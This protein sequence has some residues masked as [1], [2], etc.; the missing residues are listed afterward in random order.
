M[1]S[2][3]NSSRYQLLHVY[4][5]RG[6]C[7]EFYAL[8]LILQVALAENFSLLFNSLKIIIL[9]ILNFFI[10]TCTSTLINTTREIYL[11][12]FTRMYIV[13]YI[14]RFSYRYRL[15]SALSLTEFLKWTFL[16][17]EQHHAWIHLQK[18]NFVQ[19][20]DI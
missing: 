9:D 17:E 2:M 15:S 6:T 5:M 12:I 10:S 16:I 8:K 18:Y 11:R 20:N 19:N 4:Y 7:S 13:N 1:T 3:F 14:D